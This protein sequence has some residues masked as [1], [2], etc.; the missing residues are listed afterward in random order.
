MNQEEEYFKQMKKTTY[1]V[2]KYICK[3]MQHYTIYYACVQL[4]YLFASTRY[5]I[6]PGN[7]TK[8]MS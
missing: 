7:Q 5:K 8:G 3:G 6:I 4:L 1:S 2:P